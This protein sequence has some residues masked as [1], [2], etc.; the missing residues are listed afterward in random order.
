[1]SDRTD[2]LSGRAD[3][4]AGGQA[5]DG[6][7]KAADRRTGGLCVDWTV[8]SMND[9]C[10][11]A[12]LAFV[13]V[14]SSFAAAS[15]LRA[16]PS[17]LTETK[18][19]ADLWRG[20]RA[21][22]R[23]SDEIRAHPSLGGTLGDVGCTRILRPA[24]T[25]EGKTVQLGARPAWVA[26][27]TARDEFMASL[28]GLPLLVRRHTTE[29]S[30]TPSTKRQ[31]SARP[32]FSS[33]AFRPRLFV[34]SPPSSLWRSGTATILRRATAASLDLRGSAITN[35]PVSGTTSPDA[36]HS[37][38]QGEEGGN[39]WRLGDKQLTVEGMANLRCATAAG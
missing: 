28:P 2:R 27:Y 30:A 26:A 29:D 24:C 6:R 9:S 20:I 4:E 32:R 37:E 8:S 18:Q 21:K 22:C 33:A 25:C 36:R 35:A 14:I 19:I 10:Q 11:V 17:S 13:R 1:M 5:A 31:P 3:G 7:T 34:L 12:L 15:S 38:D 23:G 39:R 16:Y